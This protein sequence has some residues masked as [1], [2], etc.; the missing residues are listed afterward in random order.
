MAVNS[1][2]ASYIV[3][4]QARGP[5]ELWK[6]DN[7][8]RG[9]VLVEGDRATA[10]PSWNAASRAIRRSLRYS[11]GKGYDAWPKFYEYRIMRTVGS[12]Q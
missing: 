1:N 2:H 12:E 9:G 8:P 11:E 7:G 6:F 5:L 4:T 3:T 10:F